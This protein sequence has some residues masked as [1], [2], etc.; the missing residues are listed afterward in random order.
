MLASTTALLL[1]LTVGVALADTF[2]G[3]DNRNVIEGTNVDD[4][5]RGLGGNDDLFGRLGEDRLYGG[6]GND[7]L[8]GQPGNDI[9]N[10]GANDD[11]IIG[12]DGSDE[13]VGAS[14]D[15]RI[16]MVGDGERDYVN[17]GPGLDRASIASNDLVDGRRASTV[18]TTTGLSCEILFVDGVRIPQL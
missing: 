10:G 8:T 15:D 11:A 14:G 6:D 12:N 1:V 5:I 13:G 18:V 17:C 16:I 7:E 3:N 4:L 2:V 9:L